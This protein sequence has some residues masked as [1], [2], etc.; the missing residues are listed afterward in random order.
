MHAVDADQQ[1]MAAGGLPGVVGESNRSGKR[2]NPQIK[3]IILRPVDMN[4][5][6]F[7]RDSYRGG[8]YLRTVTEI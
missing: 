1:Y 7:C 8:V 6:L 3:A 4:P 5:L 2:R